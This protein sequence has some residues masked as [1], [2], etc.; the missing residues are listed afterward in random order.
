[1]TDTGIGIS[2]AHQERIFEEFEQVADPARPPQEGTGLGLA[3]VK[4]LV[5]MHGGTIRVTSTPGQGSTFAF[6]ILAG[7]NDADHRGHFTRMSDFRVR[8]DWRP[9]GVLSARSQP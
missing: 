1:V 5:Q 8:A 3:L 6:T 4:K 2:P 7:V 9:R